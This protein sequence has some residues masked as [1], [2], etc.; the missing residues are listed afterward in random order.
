MAKANTRMNRFFAALRSRANADDDEDD[1]E[2]FVEEGIP[3]AACLF[4]SSRLT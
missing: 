3:G 4:S 2:K 1:L